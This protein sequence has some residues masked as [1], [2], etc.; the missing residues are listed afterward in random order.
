MSRRYLYAGILLTA[1]V[2]YDP[3]WFVENKEYNTKLQQRRPSIEGLS[4]DIKNLKK[5]IEGLPKK[6][7]NLRLDIDKLKRQVTETERG[8]EEIRARLEKIN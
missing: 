8:F 3:N 2:L 4:V 5:G 7:K 1:L 6:K